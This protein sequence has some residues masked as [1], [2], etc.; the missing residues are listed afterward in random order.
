[1]P[2]PGRSCYTSRWSW[3]SFY[4]L[5]SSIHHATSPC[6]SPDCHHICYAIVHSG[7]TDNTQS[8]R[9]FNT[10]LVDQRS[11]TLSDQYMSKSPNKQC[12]SETVKSSMI[13]RLHLTLYKSFLTLSTKVRWNCMTDKRCKKV[14]DKSSHEIYIPT[15]A[16]S[17]KNVHCSDENHID[18]INKL[19]SDIVNSLIQPHPSPPRCSLL[20]EVDYESMPS[21]P[22][23][24]CS[25]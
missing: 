25:L 3:R 17:C 10:R 14:T 7:F 21:S 20:C 13:K 5:V 1:M 12:V 8:D 16:V 18:A 2:G 11:T 22:I 23:F 9:Y 15:E 4:T 19:Y 24:R 6:V